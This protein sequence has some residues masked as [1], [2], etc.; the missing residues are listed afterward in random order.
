MPSHLKP[1]TE[2][3]QA[4][5]VARFAGGAEALATRAEELLAAG[6]LRLACHL[7]DWAYMADPDNPDVRKT[8][9]NVYSRRAEAEPST[10][11]MGIYLWAAA[12]MGGPRKEGLKEGPVI[13]AQAG[14]KKDLLAAV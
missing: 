14:R 1:A 4:K 2:R 6:D 11:A 7:A 5:E 3:D 12:A 8:V 13:R 9:G 10:M